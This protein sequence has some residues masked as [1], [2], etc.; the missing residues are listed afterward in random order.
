MESLIGSG[1]GSSCLRGPDAG[2]SPGWLAIHSDRVSVIGSSAATLLG[3][4]RKQSVIVACEVALEAA[5]GLHA[6]L[7]L[8]FLAL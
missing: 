6:C 5:H 4:S 7:A 1:S 2:D 8:G 3:A